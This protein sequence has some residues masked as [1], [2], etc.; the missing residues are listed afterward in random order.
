MPHTPP[1]YRSEVWDYP[2]GRGKRNVIQTDSDAICEMLP[3]WRPDAAD[4]GQEEY[5][6]NTK[7]LVLAANCHENLVHAL[8]MMLEKF[9]NGAEVF[10]GE[11]GWDAI[12]AAR[13]AVLQTKGTQDAAHTAPLGQ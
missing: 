6:A 13:Y 9:D 3:L 12:V 1:P 11:A 5:E 7:F 4:V 10:P 2:Q 8:E